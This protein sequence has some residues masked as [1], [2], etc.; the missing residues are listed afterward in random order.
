MVERHGGE[1]QIVS[2]PGAGTTMRLTFRV[3]EA[4]A[5]TAMLAELRPAAPSRVLVIDDDPILLKSLRDTLE[6]DGHFVMIAAGGESGI[7]AFR[8]A[9]DLGDPFDVVIT[10]LGMP[11]V[12]GRRVAAAIKST[13]PDVPVILLTGWGHRLLAE[14]DCPPHVDRVLGKPPKLAVLRA[15]LAEVMS[16]MAT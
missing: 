15:T 2:K 9:K 4:P 10:D 14:K 12:D 7:G 3:S 5:A 8:R 1:L 6:Q 13:T 16:E 11:H